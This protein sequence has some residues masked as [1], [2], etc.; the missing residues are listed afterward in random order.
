MNIIRILLVL[1]A[2]LV[3][4][5][6]SAAPASEQS[7]AILL[8]LSQAQSTLETLQGTLADIMRQGIRQSAPGRK[9]SAE[10]QERMDS[11]LPKFAALLREE[12]GWERLKPMYIQLYR[13]TYEQEEVDS[14]I[15]FYQSAAGQAFVNKMPVLMQKT[16]SMTQ[17]QLQ[18]LLPRIMAAAVAAMAEAKI[19][20]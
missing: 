11:L 17:A 5:N 14:L 16:V 9:L 18:S 15:Q 7:V 8:E 12:L 3:M 6:A 20:N 4:P 2:L 19:N 10:Q 13:D 1:A